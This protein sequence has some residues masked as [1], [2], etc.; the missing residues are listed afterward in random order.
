MLLA[1]ITQKAGLSLALGA[2]VSGVLLAETDYRY[3]VEDYIK[4]F[5]DVLLGLFF[6]TIGTLLDLTVVIHHLPAVLLTLILLLGLKL[7]T[8]YGPARAL[9]EQDSIALRTA[10]AMAPAGEF[11]FVLLAQTEGLHLVPATPLQIVLAAMLIS[12]ILA[13]FILLM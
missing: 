1:W 7:L 10:L 8:V 4:P 13:P 3:Q 5:R 9:G 12:M 6:I 11:G 2:F